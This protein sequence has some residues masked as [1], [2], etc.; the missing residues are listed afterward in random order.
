MGVSVETKL[1]YGS[2]EQWAGAR[3]IG[4]DL[5]LVRL[6]N[7]QVSIQNIDKKDLK[8]AKQIMLDKMRVLHC[9]R[10]KSINK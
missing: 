1:G 4:K 2:S 9:T 5:A 3:L 7:M 8:M 10:T 6:L